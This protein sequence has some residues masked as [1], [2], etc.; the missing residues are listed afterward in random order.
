MYEQQLKVKGGNIDGHWRSYY[1]RKTGSEVL[2][3]RKRN[4]TRNK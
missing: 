1:L 2:D 4:R 3:H